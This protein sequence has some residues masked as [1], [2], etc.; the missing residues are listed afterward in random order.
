[1]VLVKTIKTNHY[2]KL[3]TELGHV[4]S[5]KEVPKNKVPKK[6]SITFKHHIMNQNNTLNKNIILMS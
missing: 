3:D 2:L 5:Y 4:Q 6:H 1:M